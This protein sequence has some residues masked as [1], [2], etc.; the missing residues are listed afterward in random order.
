MS[1]FR[2]SFLTFFVLIFLVFLTSSFAF[3]KKW[4][5]YP[6]M[7]R[8]TIQAVIDT[9]RD[10]DVIY[11]NPGLYDFSDGPFVDRWMN[12]G[13]LRI[14]DKSL[15]IRGTADSIL[16]GKPS[17]VGGDWIGNWVGVKG[18]NC[19]WIYDPNGKKDVTIDGLSF[20]TFLVGVFAVITNESPDSSTLVYYPNLRNLT[21]KNCLFTDMH[22]NGIA[23]GGIQGDITIVNNTLIGV[24]P[25][26]RFGIYL[27][28]YWEPGHL[29]WQP[30]NTLVTIKNN[31]IRNYCFGI[32]SLKA[33]NVLITGNTISTDSINYSCTGIDLPSGLKNEATI[34]NNVLSNLYWGI[35][36][37][38]GTYVTAGGAFVPFDATGVVVKNNNISG[39]SGDAIQVAGNLA[40]GN[41]IVYNTLDLANFWAGRAIYSEGYNNK[42]RNNIIKGKAK[43][44]V[45]LSG[46]DDTANSGLFA[47]PHNELFKANSISGLTSQLAHY[48]LDIYAHDNTVI[49]LESENATY[50][51]SG[52]NNF[53]KYVY[54]Y[55]PPTA[56]TGI[57][58]S[59]P[60]IPDK[61]KET[62]PKRGALPL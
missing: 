27:D 59:K 40:F 9:A 1:A 37:W 17:D 16:Q 51:D 25:Y 61:A 35:D 31:S 50:T 33:S 49:G 47:Y 10:G 4:N 36:I 55:L 5:V 57:S 54:P 6:L 8:I 11:F 21:V 41:S 24:D 52:T 7:T 62:G 2:R 58:S 13:A 45:H 42:Y 32:Y 46:W 26:S 30:K 43:T 38:G 22:R 34:S 29:E 20:R 44:A 14:Y 60:G 53:F 3:A 28:W 48:T 23:T 18:I 15:V 39:I 12:D 19:F 56:A